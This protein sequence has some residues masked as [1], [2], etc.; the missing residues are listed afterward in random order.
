M[1]NCRRPKLSVGSVVP[2]WCPYGGKSRVL[3]RVA[4]KPR[5]R[6]EN[7]IT[8]VRASLLRDGKDL[9]PVLDGKILLVFSYLIAPMGDLARRFWRLCW[10]RSPRSFSYTV[11]TRR[12][13]RSL[14]KLCSARML[15]TQTVILKGVR[16][17]TRY[18]CI[19]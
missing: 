2:R 18:T 10:R 12:P 6:L 15:P 5:G 11:L 9:N 19:C 13:T 1:S 16:W 8:K 3:Y 14:T 4:C 17:D 7:H